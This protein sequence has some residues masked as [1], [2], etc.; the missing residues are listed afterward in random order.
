MR[1]W[2]STPS[3]GQLPEITTHCCSDE[4]FKQ[5][6]TNRLPRALPRLWQPDIN[7]ESNG[8]FH[9]YIPTAA[10]M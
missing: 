3:L 4:P 6:V 5:Q 10:P 7:E 9:Q 8:L 1:L 2:S